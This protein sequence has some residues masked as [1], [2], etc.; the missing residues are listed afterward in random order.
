MR[1][2]S[3]VPMLVLLTAGAWAAPTVVHLKVGSAE[4]KDRQRIVLVGHVEPVVDPDLVELLRNPSS[5]VVTATVPNADGTLV[6]QTNSETLRVVKVDPRPDQPYIWIYIE[7]LQFGK[8]H[9]AV[10]E[11]KD[12]TGKFIVEPIEFDWEIHEPYPLSGSSGAASINYRGSTPVGE[13][14]YAYTSDLHWPTQG[15]GKAWRRWFNVEGA[16]P[17]TTPEDVEDTPGATTDAS[18]HVADFIQASYRYGWYDGTD[19]RKVGIVART[20]GRL[21]GL[22]VVGNAQPFARFYDGGRGFVGAEFEAG[23]RRGDAEW[24]NLTTR[25][26]VH[27]N[28]ALRA[29]AVIEYAPRIGKINLDLGRGLRFYVRGRGWADSYDGVRLRGFFDSEL[30]YNIDAQNQY[31]VFARYENGALP[32]D[33]S[34]HTDRFFLGTGVAF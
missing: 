10:K 3:S 12:K 4:L 34:K 6:P 15:D 29:G 5:Y 27:G 2:I 30:F 17:L 24:V 14:S 11:M 28:L 16:L 1:T 19:L 20:T 7:G 13:F 8:G 21:N 23:Y 32:P 9:I 33:L 22:E 18:T 26:P 25:G 31:R